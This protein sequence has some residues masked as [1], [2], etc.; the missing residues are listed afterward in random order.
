ME[1]CCPARYRWQGLLPGNL[2]DAAFSL[3]PPGPLEAGM[4]LSGQVGSWS[5]FVFPLLQFSASLLFSHS[6]K[7]H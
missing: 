3:G 2:K 1:S 5:R 6:L 7:S 4:I